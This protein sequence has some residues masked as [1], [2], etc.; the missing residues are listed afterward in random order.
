MGRQTRVKR[1][2]HYL[3]ALNIISIILILQIDVGVLPVIPSSMTIE[4]TEKINSLVSN[5]SQG[6]LVSTFF[7]LLLVY[8]PER[9][10]AIKIKKLIRPRLK[11]ITQDMEISI[12][13]LRRKAGVDESKGVYLSADA[14][15]SIDSLTRNPMNF[16]YQIRRV[17]GSW[18]N[19]ST[20]EVTELEHFDIERRIVSQKINE[21]LML[22]HVTDENEDLVDLLPKIRDCQLYKHVELSSKIQAK[23]KVNAPNLNAY[24]SEYYNLY[25]LLKKVD[26]SSCMIRAVSD[27]GE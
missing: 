3:L 5:L 2:Y 25:L 14:F 12:L 17:D 9:E 7:Y 22:P 15:N 16:R 13:F 8:L 21:I 24:L 11:T 26:D 27:V 20:G 10:R 19:F 23:I 4:R 1:I 6:V 18:I